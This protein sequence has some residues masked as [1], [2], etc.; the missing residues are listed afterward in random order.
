[1]FF[2][3]KSEG[4]VWAVCWMLLS[5]GIG[6]IATIFEGTVEKRSV[7]GQ[8]SDAIFETQHP[9][10]SLIGGFIGFLFKAATLPIQIILV[11]LEISNIKNR[12]R[13]NNQVLAYRNN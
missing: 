4:T 6:F 13:Q 2:T 12:V 11:V 10:T 5:W 8:V 3:Q 9:F 1:M 7:K